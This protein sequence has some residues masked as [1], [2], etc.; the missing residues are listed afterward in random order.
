MTERNDTRGIDKDLTW[1]P[2]MNRHTTY[3]RGLLNRRRIGRDD[4]FWRAAR[5]ILVGLLCALWWSGAQ[6]VVLLW[7]HT[8]SVP[9]VSGFDPVATANSVCSYF[10]LG[11]ETPNP[12]ITGQY[13]ELY[14]FTCAP[15][16]GYGL[17]LYFSCDGGANWA[18][19]TG[20]PVNELDTLCGIQNLKNVGPICCM[21][22]NPL[23]PGY[24]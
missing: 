1:S 18:P 24:G 15:N 21:V 9:A 13:G 19:A 17:V 4:T 20:T 22:G 7:V 12:G 6:A 2:S 5:R 14:D 8:A 23:N 10:N 11:P 3:P 16:V